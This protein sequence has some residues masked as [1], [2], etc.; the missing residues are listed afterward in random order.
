[1]TLP[2]TLVLVTDSYPFETVKKMCFSIPNCLTYLSFAQINGN[3]LP[4]EKGS[5][6]VG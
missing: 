3:L 2:T 1:M 5:E 4:G 6:A